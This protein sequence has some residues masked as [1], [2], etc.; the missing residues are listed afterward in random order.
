MNR[1][2]VG[3]LGATGIV[4]QR[5]I[6]LLSNHPWFEITE[7]AASEKSAGKTYEE[8]MKHRW[9][10]G[11]EIP[12]EVKGKVVKEC[13]PNLDCKIVF[14]A[15]DASVAGPIEE[16]F[17]KEGYVVISNARN[18]RMDE[19]VP[20]LIPEVNPESLQLIE[21]QKRRRGFK[22]F[23]VTHPNC[24]T[25]HLCL[26]LKPLHEKFKIRKVIVTTMQALSGAG[27][28]GV[29]S[30]DI[31]DNIIPYIPL[32]EDKI[33]NETLKIL[34]KVENGRI[35][36][37]NISVSATCNRVFVSDGHMESVS[38]ELEN[39]PSMD[40]FI[41]CLD[42]FD[43]LKKYQL[44]SHVK[45]IIILKEEDRPQPRLDRNLA[46]GMASVVGRIRKC[47]VLDYKFLVLGNNTIRGGAGG[48]ILIAEL[49]KYKNMI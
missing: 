26:V 29:A 42:D 7:L 38:V 8:V 21:V 39:K 18:H 5:Y 10:L 9:K 35:N 19:D 23:I 31:I 32:E 34:G 43:P 47:N 27:Y 2:P 22:G 45:P 30:L 28:P 25:T 41:G 4:G 24:S 48:A 40:E 16:E 6:K 33:E 49:L 44:P 36:F 12:H 13:K 15:L 20:L 37:A 3:I 17:A 1:I 46:N 14:S 11:G